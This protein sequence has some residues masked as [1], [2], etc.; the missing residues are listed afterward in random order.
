MDG[1][2]EGK[3]GK[4][5]KDHDYYDFF[6]L[7]ENYTIHHELALHR[8]YEFESFIAGCTSDGFLLP[9]IFTEDETS[10]T[11]WIFIP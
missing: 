6:V 11:D 9:V 4:R 1:L 8:V 5:L 10:K 3:R 2:V 7:V